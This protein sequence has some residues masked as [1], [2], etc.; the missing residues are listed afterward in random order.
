MKRNQL[1]RQRVEFLSPLR[2]IRN[3]HFTKRD[4][5]RIKDNIATTTTVIR[6]ITAALML[7]FSSLMMVMM[8]AATNWNQIEVYGFGSLIAQIAGLIGYLTCIVLLIISFFQKNDRVSL[9]LNRIAAYAVFLGIA[10]QMLFGIYADAQMGFSTQQETLSGSI[11]FLAV[12]LVLQPAYWT[13]AVILD[14]GTTIATIFLAVYCGIVF[15]M[16]CVYYYVVIAL[17]F[18][19]CS[20]FIST[21]LFY[22]ECQHY[23]DTLE[24]ERLNNK[25]YYDN[26]TLCKNRHALQAFISENTPIWENEQNLKLLIIM[27]DI[28]NFKEYNDTFSH[29][30]GD[31]CLKTICDEVRKT[32]PAPS[33][34]FYRYGGEEFLLFFEIDEDSDAPKIM[35]KLRQS[36]EEIGL[37]APKEAPKNIVTISVGGTLIK[38]TKNFSFEKTFEIVDKNLYNVKRNGKNACSLDNRII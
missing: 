32:F 12:L 33:L 30:A 34:D 31:Y 23:K 38:S 20:Y 9:I 15:G 16:K 26:L 4:V 13:D 25:A 27:F 35:E 29:L 5:T 17:V 24:N 37:E 2:L 1:F 6:F 22:A 8:G 19:L 14:S 36:I 21:L 10:L 28:D 18:P 3:K 11:I 7:S